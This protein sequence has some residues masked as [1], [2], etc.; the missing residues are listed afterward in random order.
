MHLRVVV[1]IHV[2]VSL[3]PGRAYAAHPFRVGGLVA[4]GSVKRAPDGVTVH[5]V[6]TDTA[7]SIPVVYKGLLPDLFREGKGVVTQGRLGADGVFVAIGHTPNT[8]LFEGQLE[9]RNGYIV[10]KSGLPSLLRTA[11]QASGWMR[12]TSARKG[13]PAA[14]CR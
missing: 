13:T 14:G 1:E 2:G 5:F 7:K 9:M 12:A 3:L 6:V 8:Q 11:R 4:D 10:T